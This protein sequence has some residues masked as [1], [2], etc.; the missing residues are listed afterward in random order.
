[1][2]SAS[3]LPM[4]TRRVCLQERLPSAATR[5]VQPLQLQ[6][7]LLSM[8]CKVSY[9]VLGLESD[10]NIQTLLTALFIQGESEGWFLDSYFSFL[11]IVMCLLRGRFS[12]TRFRTDWYCDAVFIE[13]ERQSTGLD[14][15]SLRSGL[16]TSL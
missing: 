16:R 12:G 14:A 4:S 13:P 10:T 5:R 7:V 15:R 9:C 2:D 3:A 8:Y 6:D 1:V 11:W